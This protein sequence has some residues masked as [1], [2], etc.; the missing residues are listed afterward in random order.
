MADEEEESGQRRLEVVNCTLV[1]FFYILWF[2][3]SSVL[4]RM[5][6]LIF[7]NGLKIPTSGAEEDE[8]CVTFVLHEEDHTLGNALR[9]TITKKYVNNFLYTVQSHIPL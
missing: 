8:T 4:I 9:Y 2:L 7:S 6:S 1:Q 3:L 5:F